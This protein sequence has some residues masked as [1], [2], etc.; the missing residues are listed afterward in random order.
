MHPTTKR[1]DADPRPAGASLDPSRRR[2]LGLLAGAGVGLVGLV[3]CGDRGGDSSATTTSTTSG[4]S[5]PASS[6]S[7]S[8]STAGASSSTTAGMATVSEE[9]PEETGGPYPADGTNGPDVLTQ[10]GVVRRDLTTSFGSASGR[11]EGVRLT[12]ELRLIDVAGGG[13]AKAGAAVY[14]WHCSREGEYS[15]YSQGA[16]D[17]N[18]LRGVQAAGDDG[19]VTFTTIFPGCYPGRWPHVHFEVYGSVDDATGGGSK[20]VTSQLAL[21]EDV[22]ATAY[23]A[24]GYSA[25]VGNLGQL[26]LD[27][28]MV[29]SDG[30]SLQ[31]ATVTGSVADG[32]VARLNVGV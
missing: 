1:P 18:W 30:Y 11:A 16:T 17:Q 13:G 9:I 24:D 2:A 28:D 25:S 31:L 19:L 21:P 20:L 22:C 3:A 12:L 5:S 15:L 6:S 26:S 23:E 8:S 27:R 32:F 7:S 10:E 4:S 29:F 14:A